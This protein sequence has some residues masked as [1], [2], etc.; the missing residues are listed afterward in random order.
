M[1]LSTKD[2]IRGKKTPFISSNQKVSLARLDED[3]N[4]MYEKPF[5]PFTKTFAEEIMQDS[6]SPGSMYTRHKY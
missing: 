5:P 2:L 1:P 4:E 6:A 3:I